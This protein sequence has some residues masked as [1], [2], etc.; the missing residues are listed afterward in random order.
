M[1]DELN[2]MKDNDFWDLVELP[3]GKRPIGCKWVFKTKWDSK[4][5]I[6][7]YKTRLIVKEFTQTEGIDYN[8]TFSPVF[9]KDS[10]RIIMT[11]A[12]HF[13]LELYQL[14]VKTIFLNGDTEEEIYM[15][16][17]DNFEGKGS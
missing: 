2:S 17:P 12:T 4:C 9:M 6:E 8:E 5:N 13:D 15:V 14:D 1:K 3:K 7:R 16:Q 10:F 11:L